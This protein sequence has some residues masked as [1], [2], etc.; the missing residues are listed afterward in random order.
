M[1]SSGNHAMA[2]FKILR[3]LGAIAVAT[4]FS[5]S[6]VFTLGYVSSFIYLIGYEN[7]LIPLFEG[8]I[9]GVILFT[10]I[11][12]YISRW[13]ATAILFSALASGIMFGSVVFIMHATAFVV[14]NRLLLICAVLITSDFMPITAFTM[15]IMGISGRI[16]K[17]SVAIVTVILGILAIAFIAI[18]YERSGQN[19]L[20][21][22]TGSLS[23]ATLG[24]LAIFL[25]AALFISEKG[26]HRKPADP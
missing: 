26:H 8:I 23:Y 15:E 10:A 16:Q 6:V 7:Q 2:G 25:I 20:A 12:A 17:T 11:G 4:V 14:P 24:I 5:V 19:D 18:I 13:G 21:F 9:A 3:V 22:I 1:E